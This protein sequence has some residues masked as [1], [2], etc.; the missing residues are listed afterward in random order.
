[1]QRVTGET[2]ERKIERLKNNEGGINEGANEL[3]YDERA[4]GINPLT[5]VRTDKWD[6]AI[7][8]LNDK[9]EKYRKLR[10]EHLKDEPEIEPSAIKDQN[11]NSGEEG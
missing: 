9:S 6:L 4:D 11:T 7:E 8:M 5:D 2:I 1:M 10:D 3:M